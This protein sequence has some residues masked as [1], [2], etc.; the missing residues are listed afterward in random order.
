M[1]HSTILALSTV[2]ALMMVTSTGGFSPAGARIF[3][4]QCISAQNA[5]H[6][7]CLLALNGQEANYATLYG[8]KICLNNCD[9]GFSACL[10]IAF[11]SAA[12]RIDLSSGPS[13]NRPKIPA[14]RGHH[15]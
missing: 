14:V 3:L 4:G 5:C 11:S 13:R 1:R 10:D 9:G 6:R 2:L 12:G 15:R 8:L 7:R